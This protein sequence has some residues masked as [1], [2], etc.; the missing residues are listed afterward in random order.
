MMQHR[1][2]ALQRRVEAAQAPDPCGRG[3]G[4]CLETG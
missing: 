3:R 1:M 4:G 2:R